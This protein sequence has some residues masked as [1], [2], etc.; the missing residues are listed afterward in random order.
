MKQTYE[1]VNILTNKCAML[2]NY[3]VSIAHHTKKIQLSSLF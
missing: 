2:T 3:Y 1:K